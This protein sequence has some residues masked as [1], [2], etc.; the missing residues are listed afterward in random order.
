[1]LDFML[2]I[3]III[4][5]AF[6]DYMVFNRVR[7]IEKYVR[8]YRIFQFVLMVTIS[9]LLFKYFGY[10]LLISVLILFFGWWCDFIYYILFDTLRI[11]HKGYAGNAYRIEV[12]GDNVTWAWWT[13]YGWIHT[14]IYG[15]DVPIKGHILNIQLILTMLIVLLINFWR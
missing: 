13:F 7:D 1:M 2:T 8:Y 3:S 12:L 11:Y 15:K 14:L 4:L 6:L 5:L 9:A 10:K